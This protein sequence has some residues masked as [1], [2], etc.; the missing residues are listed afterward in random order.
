MTGPDYT[1]ST[2]TGIP[3][4]SLLPSALGN[5][6]SAIATGIADAGAPDPISV[7]RRWAVVVNIN[8]D[9]TVDI[10]LGGVLVPHVSYDAS[11]HPALDEVVQVNVVD[12]DI[13]VIGPTANSTYVSYVRRSGTVVVVNRSGSAP[14][15]PTSVNVTL[16][17]A[18][19]PVTILN[20][21]YVSGYVP[22]VGDEVMLGQGTN[23]NVYLVLGAVNRNFR[24]PTGDIEPSLT[25]KPDTLACNG[26][27]VSRTTYAALWAWA[28]INGLVT[29]GLFGNGNGTTTFTV[30][31]FQ[32]RVPVGTGTLGS[33]TY[34]LG[35]TGGNARSTLTTDQMP[36]HGHS[37]S[38]NNHGG[39]TH[40]FTDSTD[41][42]GG[43]FHSNNFTSGGGGGHFHSV[44]F[45]TDSQGGHFHA[46]SFST[47]G[48]GGHFHGTAMSVGLG[49]HDHGISNWASS[50]N[51]AATAG[52]VA[53]NT[54]GDH[55]HLVSGN[56]STT[57]AHFHNIIGDTSTVGTH[58]HAVIGDTSSVAGHTHTLGGTTAADSG[59][60]HTVNQSNAGGS[61]AV[62][63]RSPYLA[64]HWIIWT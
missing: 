42:G 26:Q 10:D 58:G 59:L 2:G 15:A 62:D 21:P 25:V 52:N 24:R 56:T 45:D 13:T 61:T 20:V 35:A 48:A 44:N 29:G 8:S 7:R 40:G 32:G 41:A 33:D 16:S 49:S 63:L 9:S 6:S 34:T 37:V 1:N 22:T 11:Y 31:N 4:P 36:S 55:T 54:V 28:Q 3:I 50:G 43:H 12:T 38:V 57:G 60:T 39:H 46:I 23:T 47:G 51:N 18:Q 5:T 30:P 14:G 17:D 27:A 19:N 64:V 53:T